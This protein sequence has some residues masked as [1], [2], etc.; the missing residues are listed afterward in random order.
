M[1]TSL[2][3]ITVATASSKPIFALESKEVDAGETV[4]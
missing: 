4:E 3:A 2:S 1:V